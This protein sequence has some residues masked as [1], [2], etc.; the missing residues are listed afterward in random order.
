MNQQ[1]YAALLDDCELCHEARLVYMTFRRYMDI[2]TGITGRK[3]VVDYNELKQALEYSPARGS[4]E[5]AKRYSTDQI[6]RYI[7]TL[8][9]RGFLLRLHA[10]GLRQS[11]IFRLPLATSDSFRPDEE[12][13]QS[14]TR[15]APPEHPVFTRDA[16]D[17]NATRAPRDERHISDISDTNT[18]KTPPVPDRFP[19]SLDWQ[20]SDVF[21]ELCKRSALNPE[22]AN[23]HLG[24]FI[25][26]YLS[27]PGRTENQARWDSLLINWMQRERAKSQQQQ[28]RHLIAIEGRGYGKHQSASGQPASAAQRAAELAAETQRPT[29]D[30]L[31]EEYDEFG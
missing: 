27:T 8:V 3:R 31:G 20:P 18:T 28:Q 14:A 24:H 21:P 16:E 5:K 26:H 29:G 25:G 7:Q 19:M 13:H 17:M 6:K 12:R 11:M 30:W 10:S 4:R 1:E 22:D 2:A 23:Q 15:A 9:K